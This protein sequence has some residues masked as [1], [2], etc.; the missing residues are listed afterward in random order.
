MQMAGAAALA[1]PC[2]L[3]LCSVRAA[4][5]LSPRDVFL[6]ACGCDSLPSPGWERGTGMSCLY[7]CLLVLL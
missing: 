6:P 4:E 5:V 1:W 2:A 3:R 7:Y